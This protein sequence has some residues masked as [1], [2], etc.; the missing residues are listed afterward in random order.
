MLL[1]R[2]RQAYREM[3]VWMYRDPAALKA[4]AAGVKTSADLPNNYSTT[5]G[6]SVTK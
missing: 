2:Y 6:N 1:T 5:R 4:Y 3:L